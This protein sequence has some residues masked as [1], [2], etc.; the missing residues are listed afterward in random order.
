MLQ[1]VNDEPPVLITEQV[2]CQEGQVAPLT[3]NS[4]YIIDMDTPPDEL[5]ITLKAT[6]KQGK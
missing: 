5:E 6:P 4:V 1:L 3:N 2:F